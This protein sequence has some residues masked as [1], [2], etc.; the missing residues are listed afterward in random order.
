MT[1]TVPRKTRIDF[2]VV[3]EL[4]VADET[5]N[6]ILEKKQDRNITVYR[7]GMIA[8]QRLRVVALLEELIPELEAPSSIQNLAITAMAVE[9]RP[10]K[11]SFAF[12]AA[13]E[14][15]WSITLDSGPRLSI[16]RLAL[17]VL[18][19]KPPT[20]PLFSVA[21]QNFINAL[22]GITL[23]NELRTQFA[24]G[25]YSLTNSARVDIRQAGNTWRI[26]DASTQYE[27]K[28]EGNQLNVYSRMLPTEGLSQQRKIAFEGLFQLFG[29]EFA[30]RV[31]HQFS[32]LTPLNSQQPTITSQWDFSAIANNISV[33]EIIKAFGFSQDQLD[34]YGLRSLVVSLAFTL[35]Q[36]RYTA[37]SQAH[38]RSRYTFRGELLWDTGIE[39]VPGAETLQIEAAVQIAKTSSTEPGVLDSALQGWISG[40]VRASIPFFDTLQLSVIYT[41]TKTSHSTGTAAG[42]SSQ[43][44]ATRTGELIFQLQ[45]SSLLLTAVYTSVPD[46]KAPN[47]PQKNRKLLRFNVGLVSGKN[48]TIGDLIAYIVSLYDP[49]ITDFELDPPWDQFANQE[50]ALNKFSLEIDLTQ[51]TVTI[52]YQAT[53]DVLIAKVS[54]IGLSYQFGTDPAQTQ[55]QRNQ[56][57]TASNKKVAIA[58]NLS[59]PGQPQQRVQWDPVNENPPAV[60]GTNVPIFELQ[61]LALGQ[62]VAFAP[63]IIQQ[64]RTIQ[65][66]TDVMRQSLV[67]LPPAK[68]RQNPLT[69][70]QD[71]LPSAVSSDPSQPIS[72]TGQPIRFSAESGW[73]IGAQFSILGGIDISVIFNDPFVYGVRVSLSGPV[74]QALAG[75]E[76]EILYRRIS[77]TIGVYRAELTLPDTMRQLEFGAVSV[78]LPSVAVAIYTNGDF[79]I[80]VGFPWGGDF[81]RSIAVEVLI[82]LGLGGFYFNKLSAET[83]TSVPQILDG[84]FDPVLEF[85]IGLRVGLGRT[86]RKGVLSAEISITIHGLLQGVFATF[87]PTDTSRS[88]A[89]YYR[90]QGGVAIIGRIYGVVN[91]TVIQVD[92]E[93]IAKVAVLFVVEVHKAIHVALVATVSVKASIKVVFV[94]LRF[95]FELTVRQEFILGSDSTPPWRLAA[96]SGGAMAAQVPVFAASPCAMPVSFPGHRR[97]VSHAYGQRTGHSTVAKSTRFTPT[98][99]WTSP[100]AIATGTLSRTANLDAAGG[101]LGRSLRWDDGTTGIKLA[102][103]GQVRPETVNDNKLR[104]DIYFQTAFTK[105]ET[106]V[107]GIGL[108]FIE[109]SIPADAA[110]HVDND[111]DFDEL[112]K[113]LLTWVI[114]ACLSDRERTSLGVDA[115][116]VRIDD[117]V[118]SQEL[119]EEIYAV[120]VQFLEETPASQFW[121]PL[122]RFLSV[123]FIFD[124][125]DRPVKQ[126]EISGTI[127]PMVPQLQM[128]LK[129]GRNTV[130]STVDFDGVKQSPERIQAIRSYFQALHRT[131]DPST[132]DTLVVASSSQVD[133]GQPLAIAELLFVDYFA[134][135]IRSVVQMGIDHIED[136]KEGVRQNG[137]ITVGELLNRLNR[138]ESFQSLAGMTSRF[139][140]HG[141]RLPTFAEGTPPRI[142]GYEAAYVTTGQQF[143]VTVTSTPNAT[144]LPNEI[145]LSKPPSL[146]WIRLIDH[147]DETRESVSLTPHLNYSFI[148]PDHNQFALIQQLDAAATTGLLPTQ[149][150]GLLEI[151]NPTPQ[152]YTIRQEVIYQDAIGTLAKLL[153]LPKDLCNYLQFKTHASVV[154]LRYNQDARPGDAGA[155]Q[156]LVETDLSTYTWATKIKL[157]VKRVM[158]SSS[159]E[160][161]PTT[162]GIERLDQANKVL[163][164]TILQNGIIPAQITLFYLS[165]SGENKQLTSHAN[166]TVSLL[167]T[168][169]S[170]QPNAPWSATLATP[171]ERQSF[172]RLLLEGG[173]ANG[174]GYYLHYA[175]RQTEQLNGLPQAIFADDTTATLTLLLQFSDSS[176]S[177]DNQIQILVRNNRQTP[178]LLKVGTEV[179][180]YTIQAGDTFE[181][182]IQRQLAAIPTQGEQAALNRVATAAQAVELFST[183]AVRNPVLRIGPS[184]AP[185]VTIRVTTQSTL[186]KVAYHLSHQSRRYH[187]CILVDDTISVE[188]G[189]FAESS[190]TTPVLNIP[191]GNLGFHLTRDAIEAEDN[192]TAV[193]EIQNLYQLLRYQVPMAIAPDFETGSERLPMGPFEEDDKATEWVYE[194]V[195]PVYALA[196]GDAPTPSPLPERL[197]NALSPYR[198]IGKVFQLEFRWQDIYGN[199]LGRDGNFVQGINQKLGYFDPIVG[200]NQWPSVGE[201]YTITPNPLNNHTADLNLELVFDQAKYVPTAT[202][203]L[204]EA[205]DHIKTDRATYQQIYYQVHDPN[206]SFQVKTSILPDWQQDLESTRDR[207]FFTDFVDGIYR[208]LVTLES[209]QEYEHLVSS[210]TATLQSVQTHYGVNLADLANL[211]RAEGVL[212]G[213]RSIQ[214]PV[215]VRVRPNDSLRAIA[216]QLVEQDPAANRQNQVQEKVQEIVTQYAKTADLLT[217]EIT[218][219]TNGS[220]NYTVQP[221]DTFE[222]VAIA[223]LAIQEDR[224]IESVLQT[225]AQGLDPNQ[226]LMDGVFIQ[227]LASV[228]A[229]DYVAL[230][231]TVE[232]LAYGVLKLAHADLTLDFEQ[233]L[234]DRIQVIVAANGAAP[235]IE[236][237]TIVALDETTQPGDTLSHLRD[238]LLAQPE[239]ANQSADDVLKQVAEA[240]RELTIFPTNTLLSVTVTTP[241]EVSPTSVD[242]TIRVITDKTW[243]AIAAAFPNITATETVETIILANAARQDLLVTGVAIAP[244][245]LPIQANDSLLHLAITQFVAQDDRPTAAD[246][247]KAG[248][249][250]EIGAL[251]YPIADQALPRHTLAAFTQQLHRQTNR[252]RTVVET[253]EAV[254]NISGILTAEA[255][256]A[257]LSV[258]AAAISDR[259]ELFGTEDII[260]ADVLLEYTPTPGTSFD[261]IITIVDSR[262]DQILTDT[263]TAADIALHN[264][265]M[266]LQSG[267]S[268]YIP[269]RFTLNTD[270]APHP[271]QL[272]LHRSTPQTTSLTALAASMGADISAA[273][274]AIANQSRMNLLTA[275]Q[276]L[277]ISSALSR[278]TAISIDDLESLRVFLP[279]TAFQT[280]S[281]DTLYTLKS[282]L[283]SEVVAPLQTQLAATATQMIKSI[284]AVRAI[285][286]QLTF[287]G[288]NRPALR[289]ALETAVSTLRRELLDSNL[290]PYLQTSTVHLPSEPMDVPGAIAT[291]EMIQT[292]SDAVLAARLHA[293][294]DTIY[295]MYERSRLKTV[296]D[297]LEKR[298]QRPI[299]V[300][301]IGGA[302]ADVPHLVAPNQH[303]II[304]PS[305]THTTLNMEIQAAN[306]NRLRYPQD[307]IFAM[308]V[309]VAMRRRQEL[310]HQDASGNQAVVAE[311]EAISAYFSPKTVAIAAATDGSRE[312]DRQSSLVPFAA[313]F[314]QA[315]PD[316]HLA[317][318]RSATSAPA[319][320]DDGTNP[321]TSSQ[322]SDALWAVHLGESGVN[323]NIHEAFPFFFSA[324]PITNTLMSATVPLYRY[325]SETGLD[326]APADVESIRVDAVDLNGLARTYLRAIEDILQPEIAVP[327][328]NSALLRTDLNRILATKDTLAATISQ[329]VM[330]VLEP[331]LTD[332]EAQARLEQRRRVAAAA[333]KQE[334]RVNLADAYDIETIVQYDVEVAIATGYQWPQTG[335]T[336]IPCLS[337]QPTII[338][339]KNATNGTPFDNFQSLDFALSPAKL[340]L[341]HTEDGLAH[342]TFFF[343][344]E[345]PQRYE[346]IELELTYR[347]H[348]LECNMQEG[349]TVGV[350][351]SS[352]LSFV[353]PL[354]DGSSH[355][356]YRITQDVL[357]NLSPTIRPLLAPWLGRTWASKATF[358]ADLATIFTPE[359]LNPNKWLILTRA[360]FSAPNHIGDVQIPIPLRDYPIPPSLIAH[361]GGASLEN[362]AYRVGRS[363]LRQLLMSEGSVEADQQSIIDALLRDAQEIRWP[364]QSAFANNV[365][366]ALTGINPDRAR[367]YRSRIER[368]PVIEQ[369]LHSLERAGLSA[370]IQAQTQ[371]HL[372]TL[373]D[374]TWSSKALLE[375]SLETLL[376]NVLDESNQDIV[377]E[378]REKSLSNLR[379]WDYVFLYE[380]PDVAQDTIE[381][382][383]DYN[384]SSQEQQSQLTIDDVVISE[385]A[386]TANFTVSLFP[387]ASNIVTVDYATHD[388]TA[389]AGQ[390]YTAVSG[391]L[392]FAPGETAQTIEV[393][394]FN[395]AIVEENEAFTVRLDNAVGAI[396]TDAE[397][398][399]T[400]IDAP[401]LDTL[402]RF[403]HLYPTLSRDLIPLEAGLTNENEVAVAHALKAFA[404][405]AEDVADAWERW[406]P[407]EQAENL[408]GRVHYDID[409][410]LSDDKLTKTVTITPTANLPEADQQVLAIALPGFVEKNPARSLVSA[411]SYP[412]EFIAS[413][414][415]TGT[416]TL[417]ESDIPDRKLSVPGLD[418]LAYQ[419]A[420]GAIRLA[421]NKNL[422]NGMTTNPAFIFQTPQVRFKNYLTPLIVN[423]QRWD[424]GSLSGDRSQRIEDHLKALFEALLPDEIN[425]PFDIRIACEYAFALALG[426]P[427]ADDDLLASLPVLLTPRF[428]VQPA[429]N[430]N[431][432]AITQQ[433]RANIVT[434][435][436]DWYHTKQPNPA[437]G[438]YIFSISLFSDIKQA[439]TANDNPNQ[440]LLRVEHLFLKLEDVSDR[441]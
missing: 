273:A 296:V 316:L 81:A 415:T 332:A 105:S 314:Q 210:S 331:T 327:A 398:V 147:P 59:I 2:G 337:G 8:G 32:S 189:V 117:Q 440:P 227:G 358:V 394:I 263:L 208:Y 13:I 224:L 144:I 264:P 159:F 149:S 64:A 11:G 154:T 65:Q 275:N 392:T 434:E 20:K 379:N 42:R 317:V 335:S 323:Y 376:G 271:D 136:K 270:E 39:L 87:N 403:N 441:S 1:S 309:Q 269:D 183:Y 282:R 378:V 303:W 86:F 252:H 68:R 406:Q 391:T 114:Y 408:R 374:Q 15:A 341:D 364:S 104:L 25:G 248:S 233:S 235:V 90:V 116:S 185:D 172:L 192:D 99:R 137:T 157:T 148:D 164:E 92:V 255:I 299:T 388:G 287:A 95:S 225:L 385:H 96:Q 43:A 222:S 221:G 101:N 171:A 237:M 428:A 422:I 163:L 50:I 18:S 153:E 416:E 76:F 250:A 259:V 426:A 94:R 357:D 127:F 202:N 38:T 283:E 433:L 213:G 214:I 61:F 120:F 180:G 386:G 368:A 223:Q 346:D 372:V 35:N 151:Y 242:V 370:D 27:I 311:A 251:T 165:E 362:L 342:L 293:S 381:C 179:M 54:N 404:E 324:A 315:L 70:L 119:L 421:R 396:I 414:S 146:T 219:S 123:N 322:N 170:I 138:G 289:A 344:T 302:I 19:V 128:E 21:N 288:A 216:T 175:Y 51:K 108:L 14:N 97:A 343:N 290:K 353:L 390:D 401:L 431:M 49:S 112:V 197:T 67:P 45:I 380:H 63:E 111:T 142:N 129:N 217:V 102:L 359:L 321:N 56:A 52:S 48:P 182:L 195:L 420:W 80:D 29:G 312:S 375:S 369:I 93:V 88:K 402:V 265:T 133:S 352:W 294:L 243:R 166:A 313:A 201:S 419:N 12:E 46:P 246:I 258:L 135:I 325:S 410:V 245:P 28:R 162:Y 405:L 365:T 176:S 60:P 427:G 134:L 277:P 205:L 184:S 139:L 168:N 132:A 382:R 257:Q 267:K 373:S 438:R 413:V 17:S 347:V 318:G 307:L 345:S 7:G 349:A 397:G 16:D 79:E 131:H 340:P 407:V 186:E 338:G 204:A 160:V 24:T 193:D 286:E 280:G 400:I 107:Q 334:F 173:T 150:P 30:V 262:G 44:L 156:A 254:G 436:Q 58:L 276:T 295:R 310:L 424:I 284:G 23:P 268:L 10:D 361:Q 158:N 36:V 47:D 432:L 399:G 348:E 209:F 355:D 417:G 140:L 41:F 126:D 247:L 169:L 206:L 336:Q 363:L 351:S 423:T 103:P 71:A 118:L 328:A 230:N 130:M 366:F 100:G 319:S 203:P 82:F 232:E 260:L 174:D 55:T 78:T 249:V 339:A 377:Q 231:P 125:T 207:A 278:L 244:L 212:A 285:E 190:E 350:S 266:G 236:G 143:R 141:L 437:N 40:T 387:P 356:D 33:S 435:M 152:R 121:Q 305:A 389:T 301:E 110:D 211:N 383:I 62:R 306:T 5:V 167:K 229:H 253:V 274:V 31:V 66:F 109:N 37:N 9:M 89:T 74:V 360:D 215:G 238:R 354:D 226:V 91:F 34:S 6:L 75:F 300:G 395:D 411:D 3:T 194:K 367:K 308:T 106:G 409:E 425:R 393:L 155:G 113:A 279:T 304:P 77:D 371:I 298:S 145:R 57:R 85:G 292:Q 261:A 196:K 240:V 115:R 188:R 200:I 69:A 291:L 333:L 330:P 53:L 418:I 228:H 122:I 329:S 234:T 439:N 430:Q 98:H 161:L 241:D 187:N 220:V 83:A 256:A 272:A 198:G 22:N 4:T 72:F 191:A 384:T 178:H 124:I 326:R 199:R 218:I 26:I 412:F 281:T 320:D 297:L 181:T 177:L 239:Y 73:L 429:G 84:T